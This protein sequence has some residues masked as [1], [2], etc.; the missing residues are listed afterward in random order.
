MKKTSSVKYRLTSAQIKA[1]RD[2]EVRRAFM[3]KGRAAMADHG[4][5]NAVELVHNSR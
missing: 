1:P 3:E 4:K 2:P 5:T